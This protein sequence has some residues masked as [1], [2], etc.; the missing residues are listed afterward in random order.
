MC[1]SSSTFWSFLLLSILG[2]WDGSLSQQHISPFSAVCAHYHHSARVDMFL[3][4]LAGGLLLV[5]VF[6]T[7]GIHLGVENQK[8]SALIQGKPPPGTIINPSTGGYVPRVISTSQFCQKAYGFEPFPYRYLCKWPSFSGKW[9]QI[10]IKKT[11]WSNH[12]ESISRHA[13]RKPITD[14][15]RPH[16][17]PYSQQATESFVSVQFRC[18][19]RCVWL[20]SGKGTAALFYVHFLIFLVSFGVPAYANL[21]RR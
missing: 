21:G 12:H 9:V 3:G 5:P 13:S 14:G 15:P 6:V 10:R 7:V 19:I 18:L 11:R 8:L 4:I 16:P 2:S 17:W 20:E 1:H